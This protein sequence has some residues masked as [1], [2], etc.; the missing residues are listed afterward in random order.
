MA[1]QK[2]VEESTGG[3]PAKILSTV[4]HGGSLYLKD[5]DAHAEALAQSDLHP[6]SVKR[7]LD[8]GVIS[9]AVFERT[10]AKVGETLEADKKSAKAQSESDLPNGMPGRLQLVQNGLDSLAKVRAATDEAL[11]AIKG[12]GAETLKSIREATS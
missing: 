11:L 5:N 1:K 7:L 8:A 10:A 4:R 3:G 12:I 6:E 2:E 9:G